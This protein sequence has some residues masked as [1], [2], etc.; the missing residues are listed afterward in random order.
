MIS[1]LHEVN[2]SKNNEY[3]NLKHRSKS[4]KQN[5]NLRLETIKERLHTIS[6][7]L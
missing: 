1:F 3:G 2:L 6:F 5:L 7:P 4:G